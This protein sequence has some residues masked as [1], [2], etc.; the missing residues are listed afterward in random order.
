METTSVWNNY[1]LQSKKYE[2]DSQETVVVSQ[3][4]FNGNHVRLKTIIKRA[5]MSD[6]PTQLVGKHSR[7]DVV[8]HR[9]FD[10]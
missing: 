1:E 7:E 9:E 6:F 8:T 3:P 5:D 2:K 10:K 4:L